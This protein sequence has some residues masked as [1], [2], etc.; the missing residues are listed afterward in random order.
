MKRGRLGSGIWQ[1]PFAPASGSASAQL[2]VELL[3]FAELRA[4]DAAGRRRRPQRPSFHV[5]A[6]VEEGHGAHRSDFADRQLRPQTVVHLR[7]GVVHQWTD[8]E[9]IDGLLALFTPG[10]ACI[11][12]ETA[13]APSS[14]R[15]LNLEEWALL[16]AAVAHLQVE[17]TDALRLAAPE[18]PA[19][20]KH[21]LTALVLRADNDAAAEPATSEHHIFRTYRAVVEEHFR[22]WRHVNDYASAIGYSPRTISRATLSAV[23][24]TAKRFL[25]ERVTLEAKRLLAHTD[26]TVV[27]LAGALGFTQAANFT[28][29]FTAHTGRAPSLWRASERQAGGWDHD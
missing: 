19:V 10:A 25:D 3:S 22:Q 27:E 6:L 28:T 24:V 20:L 17:Y 14:T 26:I 12:L 5:L 1:V 23:G 11:D 29:F 13:S 18:A 9:T 21:T 4:M 8:V 7:P 16:R 2:P 15:Y